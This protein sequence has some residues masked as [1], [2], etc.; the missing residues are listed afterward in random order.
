MK[1]VYLNLYKP[2]ETIV[3][4]SSEKVSKLVKN[5]VNLK[6]AESPGFYFLCYF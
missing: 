6:N 4:K 5:I 3:E 1:Y 2:I